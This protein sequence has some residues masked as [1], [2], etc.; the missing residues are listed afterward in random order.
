MAIAELLRDDVRQ[1]GMPPTSW[2]M[3]AKADRH[4]CE[5]I[6]RGHV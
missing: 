1:A 3:I 5:K 4:L 2:R 6:V